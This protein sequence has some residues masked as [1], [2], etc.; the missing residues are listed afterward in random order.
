MKHLIDR[1]KEQVAGGD[2]M[3]H[4]LFNEK[5]GTVPLQQQAQTGSVDSAGVVKCR[6]WGCCASILILFL[7]I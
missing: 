4:K 5:T 2:F 1:G 6:V 7:P 3:M